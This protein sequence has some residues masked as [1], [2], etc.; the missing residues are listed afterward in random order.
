MTYDPL[1]FPRVGSRLRG[2]LSV[3]SIVWL[4]A[5]AGAQSP[6]TAT[7]EASPTVALVNG[8]AI[9]LADQEAMADRFVYEQL[10]YLGPAVANI[11]EE[12][13]GQL[14]A[15]AKQEA[16]Q[17][18]INVQLVRQA[19][20]RANLKVG[21]EETEKIRAGRN[22][23]LKQHDMTYEQ[24]LVQVGKTEQDDIKEIGEQLQI[25]LLLES[26]TGAIEPSDEQVRAYYEQNQEGFTQ[27]PAIRTSHILIKFPG[28]PRDPGYVPPGDDV[29]AGLKKQAEAVLAM[30]EGGADFAETAKT[31]S[32][33]P[34]APNGGDLDFNPRGQMV[35]EY[36]NVA[37][38]MKVGEISD[39]VETVFGYHII[40]VTDTREGTVQP[41]EEVGDSIRQQ[42]TQERFAAALTNLLEQLR[43]DAKIEI[44]GAAAP[45]APPVSIPSTP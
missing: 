33:G 9:T 27:P 25:K 13:L 10:R 43:K 16:L 30:V 15:Q 20:D 21:D 7:V 11:P 6:T 32:Q 5:V 39:I 29:K 3:V 1:L 37:W 38:A 2:I 12:Q 24:Y 28:N 14:R 4:T 18:L 44:V 17:Q 8:D 31:H 42:M 36:D 40:K 22:E 35:P 23:L 34:R 41:F 19:K 45:A 26:R